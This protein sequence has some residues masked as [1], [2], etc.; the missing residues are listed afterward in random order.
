MNSIK[1]IQDRI[2]FIQDEILKLRNIIQKKETLVKELELQ[3][4]EGF[5]KFAIG[6]SVY[7]YGV[8]CTIEDCKYTDKGFR[9]KLLTEVNTRCNAWEKDLYKWVIH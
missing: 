9:Y 6:D 5:A 4:E 2:A 1:E 3:I 7:Y 8:K